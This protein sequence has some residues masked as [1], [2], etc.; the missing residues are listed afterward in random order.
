MQPHVCCSQSVSAW[1][2]R[3]IACRSGSVYIIENIVLET[4]P[5]IYSTGNLYLP[6]SGAKPVSRDSLSVRSRQQRQVHAPW[7]LVRRQRHRRD[8]HG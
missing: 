3:S 5:K 6:R 7:R 2:D 4:A 1:W 8:D